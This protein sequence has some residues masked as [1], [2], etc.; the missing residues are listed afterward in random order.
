MIRCLAP[1]FACLALPALADMPRVVA[2]IGPVHS[3]VARVM[4]GVGV[5]DLMLPTGVSPHGHAMRPSEADALSKADAVFWVG[6][7]L[8]PWMERAVDSLAQDAVSVELLVDA[9]VAPLPEGAAQAD[10]DRAIENLL[11]LEHGHDDHAGHGH[12]GHDHGGFD[13]HAWLDPATGKLWLDRIADTLA[14]LDP[15]NAI[16]YTANAEAGRAELDSLMIEI[17]A[18][19]TPLRGRGYITFHD[20]YSWFETRFD[21]PALGSISVSDA[22][23]ASA[24]QVAALREIITTSEAT[25]IFSEPQFDP[26]LAEILVDG[27]SVHTGV[28][29]PLG[30]TL[31]PGTELYPALLRNLSLSLEDCL[32][33]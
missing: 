4:D 1:V 13:P 18:R 7:S 9:G 24:G 17:R 27:T 8:A 5:P 29:D 10:A 20:A 25:C 19:L 2:D 21:L 26:G 6:A 3:M 22:T 11:P 31:Q 16:I 30:A 28:L 33:R 32:T 23:P 14:E 15:E 12:E